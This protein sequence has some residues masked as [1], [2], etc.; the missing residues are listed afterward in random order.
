MWQHKWQQISFVTLEWDEV[1]G[2]GFPLSFVNSHGVMAKARSK[3]K[4]SNVCAVARGLK[5]FPVR[6]V[7]LLSFVLVQTI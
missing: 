7:N 2:N 5:E 3:G 6:Q 4:I 1:C